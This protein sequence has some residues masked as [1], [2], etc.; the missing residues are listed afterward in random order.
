MVTKYMANLLPWFTGSL[1]LLSSDYHIYTSHI[2]C[3]DFQEKTP[4]VQGLNHLFCVSFPLSYINSFLLFYVLCEMTKSWIFVLVVEAGKWVCIRQWQPLVAVDGVT[5][6][7]FAG[8]F[9]RFPL[10]LFPSKMRQVE[11][12]RKILKLPISIN[13]SLFDIP[14]DLAG[15]IKRRTFRY[16]GT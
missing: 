9:M 1:F 12:S 16:T 7:P 8:S 3:T 13:S 15:Q 2:L 10:T 11:H 6:L 4:L 5:R 14:Q